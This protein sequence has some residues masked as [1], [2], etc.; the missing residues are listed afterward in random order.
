MS[1][2]PFRSDRRPPRAGS[3]R[4]GPQGEGRAA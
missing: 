2:P 3:E 1:E 4:P